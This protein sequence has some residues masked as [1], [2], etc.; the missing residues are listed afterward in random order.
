VLGIAAISSSLTRAPE[1]QYARERL[2]D[3]WSGQAPMIFT[4]RRLSRLPSNSA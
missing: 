3:P 4:I 1:N 2:A